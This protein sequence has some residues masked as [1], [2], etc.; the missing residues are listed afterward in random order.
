MNSSL[1]AI[2]FLPGSHWIL[3]DQEYHVYLSD[4]LINTALITGENHNLMFRRANGEKFALVFI[5]QDEEVQISWYDGPLQP[6]KNE[7]RWVLNSSYDPTFLHP[8][9]PHLLNENDRKAL[10]VSAVA[11]GRSSC[12][13]TKPLQVNQTGRI[14]AKCSMSVDREDHSL[15]NQQLQ[16]NFAY[17]GQ[18][19]NDRCAVYGYLL[20]NHKI[21][22]KE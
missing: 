10:S 7:I 20:A 3:E 6:L 16:I 5:P 22:P 13:L 9:F 15:V 21:P 12:R 4:P 17:E 1:S 14:Y 18:Y 2:E 8:E 11:F 19:S